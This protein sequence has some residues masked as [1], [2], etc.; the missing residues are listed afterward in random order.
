MVQPNGCATF[1]FSL[2]FI[3]A[4]LLV[5]L[6]NASACIYK[7]LLAGEVRMALVADF[8]LDSIGIF[9]CSCLKSFTCGEDLEM[10]ATSTYNSFAEGE[11]SKSALRVFQEA[12]ST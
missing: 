12:L 5:E 7:L 9:G 11:G 10:C 3:K 2:F 4:V 1:V 6:V 8:N